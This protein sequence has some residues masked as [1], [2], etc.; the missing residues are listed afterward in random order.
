MA[1]AN[2]YLANAAGNLLTGVHPNPSIMITWRH[3]QW[4]PYHLF[5]TALT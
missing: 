5:S 2:T 4:L 3:C 1:S